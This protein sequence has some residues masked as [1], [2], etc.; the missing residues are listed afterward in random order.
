M[1][2]GRGA[3]MGVN[4]KP[5]YFNSTSTGCLITAARE[6]DPLLHLPYQ[7]C[8]FTKV[9]SLTYSPNSRV[10]LDF[11]NW[12]D[13]DGEDWQIAMVIDYDTRSYQYDH[14][15]HYVLRCLKDQRKGHCHYK[16]T[17]EITT[18]Q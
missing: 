7:I 6:I 13:Y 3:G 5:Q 8:L 16:S 14:S 15:R 18:Q 9:S 4:I 10:D 1:T 17:T 12:S 2:L 11:G